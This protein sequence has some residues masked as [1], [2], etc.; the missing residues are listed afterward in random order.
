MAHPLP[1]PASA[2]RARALKAGARSRGRLGRA[3]LA[4][5]HPE[6]FLLLQLLIEDPGADS[7]ELMARIAG[8]LR[9]CADVPELSEAFGCEPETLDPALIR[10]AAELLSEAARGAGA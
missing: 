4:A 8:Q 5:R 2:R 6:T 7:P 9:L 10:G 3:E 1:S